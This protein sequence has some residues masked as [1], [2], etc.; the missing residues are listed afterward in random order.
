MRRKTEAEKKLNPGRMHS[1]GVTRVYTSNYSTRVHAR[2]F[3]LAWAICL[4]YK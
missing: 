3:C 2:G 4:W 1:R